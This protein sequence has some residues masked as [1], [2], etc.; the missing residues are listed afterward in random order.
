MV[1][2]FV[3]DSNIKMSEIRTAKLSSVKRVMY[4]TNAL[5]SK[6]TMITSMRATHAPIQNRKDKKSKSL[7]LKYKNIY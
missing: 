7:S 1:A 5:R 2:N 6:A 3:N 4:C